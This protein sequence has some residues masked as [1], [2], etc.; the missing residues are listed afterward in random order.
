MLLRRHTSICRYRN[1]DMQ[2][3]SR[4]G[5]HLPNSTRK[6]RDLVALHCQ[7]AKFFE[8]AN[9]RGQTF[10]PILL[11]LQWNQLTQA[12]DAAGYFLKQ[13]NHGQIKIPFNPNINTNPG[14]SFIFGSGTYDSASM[15]SNFGR[16]RL[17]TYSFT[18][19]LM[20]KV[21]NKF[22]WPW[23][24]R[25]GIA[26]SIQKKAK[27]SHFVEMFSFLACGVLE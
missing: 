15:Q 27:S 21:D 18:I 16:L 10:Q 2:F 25:T 12:A 20:G 9:L 26:S 13:Y 5:W 11:K 4:S 6:G 19:L 17:R 24:F 23:Y 7:G 22:C 8:K 3:I 14:A 1:I